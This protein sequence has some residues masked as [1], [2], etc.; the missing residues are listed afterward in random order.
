MN[1]GRLA[2]GD[3]PTA[4]APWPLEN[5]VQGSQNLLSVSSIQPTDS[6]SSVPIV[7]GG[8]THVMISDTAESHS[9]RGPPPIRLDFFSPAQV[10]NLGQ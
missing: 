9:A 10:F 3:T 7:P 8:L 5:N 6:G 1:P 2:D 4:S